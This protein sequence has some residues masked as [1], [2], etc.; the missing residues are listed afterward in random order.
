MVTGFWIQF[1]RLLTGAFI[2]S[3]GAIGRVMGVLRTWRVLWS[4]GR[5]LKTVDRIEHP[6]FVLA[7]ASTFL[8]PAG[9]FQR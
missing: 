7:P 5:V 6:K 1:G 4:L 9:H 2:Q 8:A 3:T